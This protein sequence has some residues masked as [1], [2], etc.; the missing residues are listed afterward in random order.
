MNYKELTPVQ[1]VDGL[2]IKRE[3]L[4]APFGIKDVNGGKLRQC[5][6]LCDGVKDRYKGIISACSIHSPQAPITC[7]CAEYYGLPCTI[8]Y[9]GTTPQLL[10]KQPMAKLCIKHKGKCKIVAHTGR[11]NV[12][13]GKA[14]KFAEENNYFVVEYGVNIL[15]H[16]DLLFDAVADQ[17]INI[18]DELD[19][20]WVTCGSGITTI[21]ILLGL[22][23]Y[24]KKVKE[25]HLV[26]TAPNREEKIKKYSNAKYFMHDL[27]HEKNFAY[28][29]GEHVI[30]NG[31]RLHPLYEA[32]T[33]KEMLKN[34][35]DMKNGKNL[36]WIVGAEAQ[37]GG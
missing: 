10:I 36:L 34:N 5:L 18:P 12:L 14:R 24:R 2:L 37:I 35:V 1:N 11:H 25:V 30:Y 4:F 31:I 26:A 6:A 27:F 29:K 20:L 8:Y 13:Y 9:G 22:E 33:F 32:K 19:S 3:D 15:D 23:K 17:V 28:E 21:G 7:A 16:E